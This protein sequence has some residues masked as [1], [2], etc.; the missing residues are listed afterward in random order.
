MKVEKYS[1]AEALCINGYVSGVPNE[2]YHSLNSKISN[3][4]LK[5]M[6]RSPAHYI[7]YLNEE[8]K[9][10]RNLVLGKA[11]H[12]AVFEPDIFYEEFKLLRSAPDRV[13]SEY[14]T[15][16]KEFGEEFVLVAPEIEKIEGITKSIYANKKASELLNIDGHCELSGFSKDPETGV[17]CK[18]RF[19]KLLNDGRAIDLKST[20]DARYY[21]FSKSILTYGYHQQQAFYSDQHEWITGN[22][23]DD[24]LFITVESSAPYSC[25]V[26]RIDDESLEIGRRKYRESLNKYAECLN[27]DEWPG[28]DSDEIESIGIP[29]WAVNQELIDQMEF[30]DE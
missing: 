2:V 17:L 28:Y 3:S 18:H 9:Q 7:A 14:K 13:C 8:K 29:E 26:Y 24:F 23:L 30:D 20:I 6:A 25:I 12:C 4:G 22:K 21:P 15:A 19:D 16:K 1:S 10:T 5:H 27:K 11:L